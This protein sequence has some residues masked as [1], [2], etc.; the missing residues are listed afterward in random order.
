MNEKSPATAGLFY[1][2]KTLQIHLPK[3]STNKKDN[4]SPD[5]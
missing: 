5:G 4:P 2:E 3:V 1:L